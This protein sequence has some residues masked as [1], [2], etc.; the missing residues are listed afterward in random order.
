VCLAETPAF[1][2]RQ[3]L[4]AG[5]APK[6]AAVGLI[7]DDSYVD[8]I[9]TNDHGIS[10]LFGSP[11]GRLSAP[12]DVP[13]PMATNRVAVA[14][15]DGDSQSDIASIGPYDAAVHIRYGDGSGTFLRPQSLPLSARP[16]EIFAHD[17]D[18]DGHVDLLIGI[19]G[20]VATILNQGGTFQE[21]RVAPMEL[22]YSE[23]ILGDFDRD[24]QLDTAALSPDS[25]ALT[26]LK[27][28]GK[29]GL[30]QKNSLQIDIRPQRGV[31][32]IL[33]ATESSISP[34]PIPRPQHSGGNGDES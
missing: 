33:P 8:V 22:P 7:N 24:G 4:N 18:R 30:S 34:S 1:R 9:V 27:G 14:D 23:L 25:F 3:D 32:Q 15:F 19:R 12:L 11:A 29:G 17:L 16:S 31:A 13:L 6:A 10:I 21:P 2:V 26:I 28:D 20:G 5:P